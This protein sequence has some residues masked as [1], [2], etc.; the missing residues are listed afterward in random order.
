MVRADDSDDKCDI[1]LHSES[2]SYLFLK[3]IIQIEFHILNKD[4]QNRNSY[5]NR[6]HLITYYIVYIHTPPTTTLQPKRIQFEK[7]K[8]ITSTNHLILSN[9]SRRHTIHNASFL[10]FNSSK[11]F[12]TS[13]RFRIY[14]IYIYIYRVT[15][16]MY[17][18]YVHF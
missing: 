12:E 15:L 13:D 1:Y 17:L 9:S 6:E 2:S 16:T 3:I 4:S 14:R 11:K 8:K 7:F 5:N 18:F 10:L